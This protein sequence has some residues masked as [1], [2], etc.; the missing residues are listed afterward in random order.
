M[1]RYNLA[2]AAMLLMV[3]HLQAQGPHA[4]LSVTPL[5]GGHNY[6]V[7]YNPLIALIIYT[8]EYEL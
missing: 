5:A 7:N 6:I 4:S 3:H 2:F 1:L 8:D